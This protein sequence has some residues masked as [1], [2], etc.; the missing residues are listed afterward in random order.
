M[1]QATKPIESNDIRECNEVSL[2]FA[3]ID[4][5]NEERLFTSM[6]DIP[7]GNLK[8]TVY[9]NKLKAE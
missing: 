9:T 8:L 1:Y 7:M 4:R 2:Y 5:S 6:Q 3:F